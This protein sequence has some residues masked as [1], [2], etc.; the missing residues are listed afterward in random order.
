MN[1]LPIVWTALVT[2]MNKDGS[3]NYSELHKLINQQE[4]AGNGLLILGSTG[5]SLN[6]S[7]SEKKEIIHYLSKN[8]PNSPVMIGV[9]GINLED[10]KEWIEFLNPFNFHSYLLV[11]PLY[12]KPGDKGQT[13]W[14]EKLM[15]IATSP[16]ILYNV[17]SRT[18]RPLSL[19]AVE[20]LHEHKNFLGIK[21]ASGSCEEFKKY[22]KAAGKGFVYSGD[23]ALLP[24]FADLG[25]C[26]VISV[27]SN[28]WPKETHEFAAQCLNNTLKDIKL[29]KQACESLFIV[30]NPIPA[31]VLLKERGDI[32]S[33]TLRLPLTDLELES[34]AILMEQNELIRN[35]FS[36]QKG[37]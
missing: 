9:G 8:K 1:Q 23:D 19:K 35:W 22:K 17:P 10:T 33:S 28:V 5:E 4:E 16:C 18:G 6:L 36:Q 2:P 11:T 12:A 26:G 15:D 37:Q 29:W 27:A 13:L 21:E 14:F 24:E 30:S 31:K 3:V 32:S 20:A 25:A 34:P 7:L